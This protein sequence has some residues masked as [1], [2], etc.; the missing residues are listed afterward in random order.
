MSI[1]M[2]HQQ[3]QPT[4]MDRYILTFP[5]MDG[6]LLQPQFSAGLTGIGI[7]LLP[8]SLRLRLGVG[9]TGPLQQNSWND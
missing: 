9:M 4:F 2:Y 6:H 5:P 7:G 1:H 3:I 8:K